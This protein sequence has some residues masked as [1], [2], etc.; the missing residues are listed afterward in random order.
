MRQPLACIAL[1]LAACG[2][3]SDGDDGATSSASMGGGSTA[4]GSETT[5]STASP[6]SPSEPATGSATA[7]DSAATTDPA[8]TTSGATPST[9]AP[10]TGDGT[11]AAPD[12]SDGTTAAPDACDLAPPPRCS[13]GASFCDHAVDCG[14]QGSTYFECQDGDYVP[15]P[16]V[17]AASC[18]ADGFDFAYGCVGTDD[19]PQFLCGKGPGTP[20]EEGDLEF[21]SDET[22]F[23]FCVYGKLGD[24]DCKKQCQEV[25]DG[26][27]VTFDSGFCL[28]KRLDPGCQC[29]NEG[30]PGCPL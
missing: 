9:T 4:D 17:P 18:K 8:A 16:D 29:C 12:P 3:K 11:T 7:T 13:P 6:G 24:L 10:D 23:Q 5:A 28:Q 21:C 26:N 30:D 27:G 22:T 25:G 19:G 15:A 2:P 20:C 1:L 14:P